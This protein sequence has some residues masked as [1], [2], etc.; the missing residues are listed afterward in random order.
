MDKFFVGIDIGNKD[1]TCS[2]IRA[3]GSKHSSFSVP[4][5]RDGTKLI[6][7]RAISVCGNNLM[8]YLRESGFLWQLERHLHMLNPKKVKEFKEVYMDNY[9]YHSLI[10]LT[11]A[12]HQAT[13]A[14]AR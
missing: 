5:N 7:D 11:R 6:L 10:L 9:C 1:N 4:N 12:R 2:F 3:D 8:Y 13:Q 14:L